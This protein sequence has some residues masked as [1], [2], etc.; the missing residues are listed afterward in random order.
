MSDYDRPEDWR[1]LVDAVMNLDR[2]ATALEGIR[3][4]LDEQKLDRDAATVAR[5][6]R[7]QA[8]ARAAEDRLAHIRPY[9]EPGTNLLTQAIQAL[10]LANAELGEWY[11]AHEALLRERG[12][13]P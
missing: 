1:V 2:I 10:D 12:L 9:S 5:F 8:V 3:A 6:R 11:E 13:E 7:L 4:H